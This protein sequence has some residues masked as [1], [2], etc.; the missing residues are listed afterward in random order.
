MTTA[1]GTRPEA[2][3]TA[4]GRTEVR[5]SA[6]V[7]VYNER[8]CVEPLWERLAPVLDAT[9]SS[10]ETVFVDDGSSD[11]TAEILERLARERPRVRVVRLLQNRGQTAA[12]SAGFAHARG[13]WIVTLDADLQNPPEEIPRLLAAVDGVDLVYGR[14]R[15]RHDGW[16]KRIGSRIGNGVRNLVTG[17]FVHDTG[18]SLKLFRRNALARIPLF[19]GMHRFLPTLFEFHGF[20]TR[21]VEVAHEPRAAGTSKYGN[22]GRAWRGLYDCFAVRWMRSRSLRYESVEIDNGRADDP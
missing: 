5:L 13:E 17:H 4:A 6:V 20:R 16:A 18:C 14:R 22:L 10:W 19:H 8:E 1:E 11:G 2:H 15:V 7:P 12:L 3:A 9:G 21:E